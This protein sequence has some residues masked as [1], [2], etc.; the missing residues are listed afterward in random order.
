MRKWIL[1]LTAVLVA[2]SSVAYGA[3]YFTKDKTNKARGEPT[4]DMA[5]VYVF[6]PATAGAAIKTW[7]FADDQFLGV[8]RARGYYYAL[9]PE[10]KHVFWAKAE[11]TS[12]VE[13]EVKAG[14][15]YYFQTAIRMGFNKARVKMIQID[16][17][18]TAK[19]FDKCGYVVPTEEGKQ[20]A[21]EI[22]AERQDR[23]IAS[24]EKRKAKDAGEEE[25]E[26][27]DE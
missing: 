11:N 17:A 26:D 13:V 21:A 4:E 18:E 9:V 5:L 23:A 24:A 3:E 12:G 10:G 1:V 20:R 8:S 2:T 7:A 15:T 6:R 25:D 19:F 14:E 22:G 27:E 16:E